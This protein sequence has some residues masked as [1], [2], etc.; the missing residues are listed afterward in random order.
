VLDG[1]PVRCFVFTTPL[2]LAQHLNIYREVTVTF[3][4]F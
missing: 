4:F 3:Q 2:E 1:M